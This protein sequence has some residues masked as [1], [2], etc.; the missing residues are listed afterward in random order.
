ML[1]FNHTA[2][3][4]DYTT[5]HNQAGS[6]CLVIIIK[7]SYRIPLGS[8]VA[9]LL[10]RQ[11]PITLADTSTGDPGCSAPE[12]ECDLSLGKSMVDILLLGSAYAPKGIEAGCVP[13]GLRVGT[14]TKKFNVFGQ[15]V[16]RT[17]LLGAIA[18]TSKPTPFVKQVISYDIAFGGGGSVHKQGA[19]AYGM[20]PVG[21]G[22]FP[23]AN[24]AD[25]NPV[26]QT[27]LLD[28]PVTNPA[29]H[30]QPMSFGPIGRSWD[31]RACYAGTYDERWLTQ[32][33]PFLP[34]DFDVKYFQSA[35]ADQQVA[36]I[37]GGE[38]VVLVNL[39]HPALSPSGRLEFKLPD[40]FMP[41][42]TTAQD[43][44]I[45]TVAARVDTL[46]IEPDKQCFSIV[47]RVVTELHNDVLRFK[48][49]EVGE[50]PKGHVVKIGLD[51]VAGSLPSR[52]ADLGN[53]G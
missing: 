46:L 50:R 14:W 39:S 52:K 5:S 53:E 45:E 15:R 9:E 16:W 20:N 35:P 43:G 8:E 25:G 42:T 49:V 6:E 18:H 51:T 29:R 33:Y 28:D 23:I 4:A 2:C 40:L 36:E 41:V 26:S 22:Y 37:V 30:Y 44:T 32:S 34:A 12:Y 19:Q 31:Q 17:H 10:P 27:E 3:A 1:F 11:V 47:W 21:L 13:V 48:R 24:H 38:T 7:G